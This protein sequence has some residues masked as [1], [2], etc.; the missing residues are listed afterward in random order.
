MLECH[1]NT[2]DQASSA[3]R[4]VVDMARACYRGDVSFSIR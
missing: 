1:T 3:G 4:R 2:M